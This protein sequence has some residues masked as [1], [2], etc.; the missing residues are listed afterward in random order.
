[1]CEHAAD[2]T[3]LRVRQGRDYMCPA[4]R[5]RYCQFQRPDYVADL[6]TD[7]VAETPPGPGKSRHIA[8]VARFVKEAV[9][10]DPTGVFPQP[11]DVLLE[12]GGAGDCVDQSIL[13][14]SLLEAVDCVARYCCYHVH[15]EQTGHCAV[16]VRLPP[17]RAARRAARRAF[18]AA[19]DQ[20][21]PAHLA[22]ER[23]ETGLWLHLDGTSP[24]PPGFDR[25]SAFD[26]DADG[27]TW[28]SDLDLVCFR[29]A[30]G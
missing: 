16:Q 13:L 20:P 10:Y 9:D 17:T 27:I 18:A 6:A 29:A 25:A 26:V 22:W 24:L 19:A 15:G 30:V 3:E 23:T 5:T 28:H 2:V 12:R 1:M 14:V 8:I 21:T 7:L 4:Q 11:V